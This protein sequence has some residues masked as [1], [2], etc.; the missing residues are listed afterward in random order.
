M[1]EVFRPLS[2]PDVGFRL[3]SY[4]LPTEDI[5]HSRLESSQKKALTIRGQ[6]IERERIIHKKQTGLS[7]LSNFLKSQLTSPFIETVDAMGQLCFDTGV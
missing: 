2:E 3:G 1:S 6:G 7:R 5:P 4:R